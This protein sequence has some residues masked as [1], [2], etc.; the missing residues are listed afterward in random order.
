MTISDERLV[1]RLG[2]TQLLPGDRIV[3]VYRGEMTDAPRF[4]VTRM[5]ERRD[6]WY[7]VTQ[8]DATIEHERALYWFDDSWHESPSG[9]RVNVDEAHATNRWLSA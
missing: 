9:P 4:D 2:H 1:R 3:Q 6:G 5:V 8:A 7:V